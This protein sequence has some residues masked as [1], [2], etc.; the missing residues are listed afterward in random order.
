MASYQN[1]AKLSI[2]LNNYPYEGGISD[3]LSLRTIIT[4]MS[5]DGNIHFKFEFAAYV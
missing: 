3:T 1:G 5:V 2:L 4:E